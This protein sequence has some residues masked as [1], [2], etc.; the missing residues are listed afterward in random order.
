MPYLD[1]QVIHPVVHDDV[2]LAQIYEPA[3]LHL[4][5]TTILCQSVLESVIWSGQCVQIS[6]AGRGLDWD[7]WLDRRPRVEEWVGLEVL[8]QV[9][10][11]MRT[12]ASIWSSSSRRSIR[13]ST[14]IYRRRSLSIIIAQP[15]LRVLQSP[16]ID[17]SK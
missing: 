4:G 2:G 6:W 12:Q 10:R 3:E 5:Q 16:L 8:E 17:H 13:P 7:D 11:E 1:Q 9:S 14:K 15:S